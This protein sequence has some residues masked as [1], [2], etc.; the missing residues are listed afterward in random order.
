MSFENDVTKQVIFMH[1]AQR[2]SQ[3]LTNVLKN[4]CH[5]NHQNILIKTFLLEP[6][7]TK[8]FHIKAEISHKIWIFVKTDISQNTSE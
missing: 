3:P 1:F 8:S 7:L 5:E 4:S 6:L 2:N